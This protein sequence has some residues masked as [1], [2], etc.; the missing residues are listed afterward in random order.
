METLHLRIHHLLCIKL[1]EGKGYS[2]E[3]IDNMNRVVKLLESDCKVRLTVEPDHICQSCPNLTDSH[4]CRLS[5]HQVASKDKYLLEEFQLDLSKT[6]TASQLF[7]EVSARITE[8]IFE[9]TCHTCHWNHAG[10]C[11]YESY[12]ER[13]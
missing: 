1:F 11:S 4:T 12:I 13:I 9:N 5:Q 2:L 10:I 6:Y 7:E 8:H 3:F